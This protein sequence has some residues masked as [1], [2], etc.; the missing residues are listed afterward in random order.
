VQ[1]GDQGTDV[2]RRADRRAGATVTGSVGDQRHRPRPAVHRAGKI[3]VDIRRKRFLAVRRLPRDEAP[4]RGHAGK[5]GSAQHR[6]PVRRRVR[7]FL[8]MGRPLDHRAVADYHRLVGLVDVDCPLAQRCPLDP[9]LNREA[10]LGRRPGLSRQYVQQRLGHSVTR[11]GTT[12]PA[13]RLAHH[14]ECL[15]PVV[16]GDDGQSLAIGE[17]ERVERVRQPKPDASHP[18]LR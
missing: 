1:L 11:P 18:P 3:L 4:R 8:K 17:V 15:Q 12:P 13:V 2:G 16:V 6:Y 9:G 5:T 7:P 10:A 14:R